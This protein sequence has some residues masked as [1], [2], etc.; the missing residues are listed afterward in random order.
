[1]A[2][3]IE[4]YSENHQT[5]TA[6][7]EFD[8]DPL[9][10]IHYSLARIAEE[11]APEKKEL[12]AP[13]SEPKGTTMA[14]HT[15]EERAKRTKCPGCGNMLRSDNKTG[16]CKPCSKATG[17]KPPRKPRAATPQTDTH[18]PEK[19]G[20]AATESVSVALTHNHADDI[21]SRL[22]LADKIKALFTR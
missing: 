1:M 6:T 20:E 10:G 4:C 14:T 22:S 3:C 18:E 12:T 16:V 17:S 8:G 13:R 11:K 15:D 9:C 19:S 21:W 5:V 7:K 2:W